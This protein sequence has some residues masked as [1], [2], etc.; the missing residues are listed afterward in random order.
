MEHFHNSSHE[1]AE[2]STL[3]FSIWLIRSNISGVFKNDWQHEDDK[4]APGND[5][6]VSSARYLGINCLHMAWLA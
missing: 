5:F 3:H 1:K 4:L 2:C 6:P